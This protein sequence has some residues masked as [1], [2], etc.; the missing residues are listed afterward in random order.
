MKTLKKS[1]YN[2][3]LLLILLLLAIFAGCSDDD[4][5]KGS[6]ASVKD[7]TLEKL[8]TYPVIQGCSTCHYGSASGPDLSKANFTSN[9][10]G[11]K[12][13]DF[14]WDDFLTVTADCGTITTYVDA[15][16]N[17]NRSSVLN[18]ISQTYNDG[19]CT[20]AIG[21]HEANNAVLSAAALID[22]QLWIENSTPAN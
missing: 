13:N 10:V 16:G 21:Y 3:R 17:A 12:R 1:L 8:F 19:S 7:G 4:E 2:S 20:S 18:S 5:N 14:N 22:F 15:G 9:L 11:K 6:T